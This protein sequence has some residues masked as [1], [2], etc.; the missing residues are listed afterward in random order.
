MSWI[1]ARLAAEDWA[2]DAAFGVGPFSGTEAARVLTGPPGQRNLR[3]SRLARAGWLAH[4]GRSRFVALGPLWARPGP[5]DPWGSLRASPFFPELALAVAG[6]VRAFG[7]R[8]KSI[9]LFGSC[10]RGSETAESD[11]D[12]LVVAGPI[13]SRL[14]ARLEEIRPIAEAATQF[15]HGA[16]RTPRRPLLPQVVVL[17]PEEL[18][19]EPPLLLDLTQDARILFDPERLLGDVLEQLRSKLR[20]LGSRRIQGTD[21]AA[22]WVLRPGA[23]A[24]EVDAL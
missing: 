22:Y 3:L 6:I 16:G 14:G 9:A 13:P 24:G 7:P 2:L 5:A 4:V 18:R 12:L 1:G 11:L 15:A 20:R 8:L 23:H 19:L 21:G 17:S 10:A